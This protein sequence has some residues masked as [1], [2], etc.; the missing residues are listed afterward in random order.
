MKCE[1][2]DV[3]L[4]LVLQGIINLLYVFVCLYYR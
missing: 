2:R 4:L 3:I 1:I